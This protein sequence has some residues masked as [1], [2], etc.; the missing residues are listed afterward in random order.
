[1][2]G[3][4]LLLSPSCTK[5]E[6]KASFDFTLTNSMV[7]VNALS[8]D[9]LVQVDNSARTIYVEVAYV[10]KADLAALEVEFVSLPDGVSVDPQKSSF[11]YTSSASQTVT[12]TANGAT[13]DY[14][15]TAGYSAPSPVFTSIALNGVAVDGSSA[16]LSSSNDL[17][18]V[19]VD[20][21]VSP[22]DT[23]VSVA[24]SEISSGAEVDFSDKLNG[25]TFT[26]K[27]EDVSVERN[28]K[29][30]T[31]GINSITR[32]WGHYFKPVNTT[33][34]FFLK[35]D[36]TP[37]KIN[38]TLNVLRTI[39]MDSKYVYLIG[40]D[41]V[42][43]YAIDIAD[44]NTVT[45][46]N[47]EGYDA[48]GMF[49]TSAVG[50]L[51]DG[52]TD[53]LLVSNMVNSTASEFVIWKWAS[54][55]SAPEKVLSYKLPE[56]GRIGDQMSVEGDWNDGK[57]WFHDYTSGQKAYAFSVKAGKIDPNPTVVS[58]VSSS[59]KTIFGNWGAVYK[60]ADNKYVW[61]GPN[62]ASVVLDID[63]ST[64]KVTGTFSSDY[65]GY[66]L[67]GIRFFSFNEE[68]YMTYVRLTNSFQDGQMRVCGLTAGTLE[69]SV[70]NPGGFYSFGLGDPTEEEVT[71][72]KNAN[73]IGNNV[74]R[75]IDG[76]IYIASF[77]PGSGLSLFAVE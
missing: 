74:I 28:I 4:M 29:V 47:M 32:V 71:A 72:N 45:Q 21:T 40:T 18:K 25:V 10:D 53:V 44:G 67:H 37:G 26:L 57:I 9:Y 36:G 58:Y 24:G 1:M 31:T 41:K 30:V 39:T 48:G 6:K 56:T 55:T 27:C 23:K 16:K 3:A 66:P 7:Q 13:A 35:A 42:S 76:K 64:A 49:V 34:D 52:D 63:G 8:Q 54:P 70:Q 50:T 43:L 14:V 33:D 12:V 2:A 20:F 5:E 75:E 22:A 51:R 62:H 15:I 60:Y 65:F 61:G 77:V 17:T 69:E 38:G 59:G 19:A 46:L 73:G 11:N 68:N